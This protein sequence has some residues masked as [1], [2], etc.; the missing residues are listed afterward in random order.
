ML[1]L[2]LR[3][4]SESRTR[5]SFVVRT[6]IECAERCNPYGLQIECLAH[7]IVQLRCRV[8]GATWIWPSSGESG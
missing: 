2:R 4:V 1:V 7:R 3:G 6:Q 8:S 5:G